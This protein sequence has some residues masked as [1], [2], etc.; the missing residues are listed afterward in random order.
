MNVFSHPPSTDSRQIDEDNVCCQRQ[1]VKIL[2]PSLG[3]MD[4]RSILFSALKYPVWPFA[5][6]L[7]TKNRRVQQYTEYFACRVQN[8]Q[9]GPQ[10][11]LDIARHAQHSLS[12]ATSVHPPSA[13]SGSTK[14]IDHHSHLNH[15]RRRRCVVWWSEVR[16]RLAVMFEVA[17]NE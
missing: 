8:L 13:A 10:I 11:C 14:P 17:T 6:S 9:I 4:L 2:L 15:D 7:P 1:S 3:S 12:T 5:P 16:G